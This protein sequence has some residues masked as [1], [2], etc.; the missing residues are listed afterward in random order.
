[1]ISETTPTGAVSPSEDAHLA[2][3]RRLGDRLGDR[4][5]EPAL[6]DRFPIGIPWP[7]PVISET[8]PTRAISL[9]KT[10][11]TP[12]R[13]VSVINSVTARRNRRFLT[14]LPSASPGQHR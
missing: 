2:G 4:S 9:P 3:T 5:P 1:V 11:I 8:T 14:D 13:V 10:P 7:A 12:V 6:P